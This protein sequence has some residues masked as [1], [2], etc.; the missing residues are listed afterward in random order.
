LVLVVILLQ[1]LRGVVLNRAYPFDEHFGE[2]VEQLARLLDEQRACQG[3]APGRLDIGH[4]ADP[5]GQRHTPPLVALAI[6][7]DPGGAQ[8][9]FEIVQLDGRDF[10]G[11]H[12][13]KSKDLDD[14]CITEITL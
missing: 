4:G 11:P 7:R 14:Q 6:D 12:T 1:G 13:R 9:Q 8:P 3:I 5:F 2:I 10:A